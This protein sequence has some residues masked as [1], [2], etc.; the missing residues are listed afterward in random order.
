[1]PWDD[2]KPTPE[3]SDSAAG[4]DAVRAA[5]AALLWQ[6]RELL[7]LADAFQGEIEGTVAD[8]NEASDVMENAAEGVA[9]ALAAVSQLCTD[10]RETAE[11]AGRNV[12]AVAAATEEL[13]ASAAVIEEQVGRTSSQAETAVAETRRAG[14]VVGALSQASA[15][16]GAIV[17]LIED[18]A[19]QTNLLALNATIEAARAGDAGKGFAVVAG[20]VKSLA[21]QTAEATQR[22]AEQ[23]A[24]I[25]QVTKDAVAAIESIG[26]AIHEVEACSGEAAGAVGQQQ[27][28]IREIGRNAQETA[29]G[30]QAVSDAVDGVSGKVEETARLADTQRDQAVQVHKMIGALEGRLGTAIQS[31][32]ARSGDY[33]PARLPVTL[34]GTLTLG[35]RR[36]PVAVDDLDAAGARLQASE[37]ADG[38]LPD[39]ETALSLPGLGA[40]R[41]RLTGDRL[42]LDPGQEAALEAFVRA[43]IA[44]DQPFID[45]LTRAAAEVSA[46]FERTV[47]TGELSLDALFDTDYRPIEGSD[48]QQHSTR[49]NAVLD[50]IL[51]PI[52]EPVSEADE[53]IA[54]CAAVDRNGYLP[55]HNLKYSKPQRP[56]DPVWNAANC[57]NRRIFTD[58]T[59]KA[60][61]ANDQPFL[62]QSYLRDMGGGAFVLMKDMTVPITV[63][64]RQWGNLRLGYKP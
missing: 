64:G 48:P 32:K 55:T 53:R 18:I 8:A 39:G 59:G 51:P 41:G 15:K 28:A 27:E 7:T 5:D 24:E 37:A 44:L 62:I 29:S 56:D 14:E 30:A 1:M 20:E 2:A 52:Q 60:A 21:G 4:A 16:I 19:S 13:A 11:A 61:G 33:A 35:G 45:L 10:L 26:A 58:R 31:T 43:H 22:I 6:R 23:I 12:E 63:R 9:A 34:T 3:D 49:Y 25:Q 47:E 50:R 40:L 42:R 46:V 38:P 17:K 54:F 57:R 36:I